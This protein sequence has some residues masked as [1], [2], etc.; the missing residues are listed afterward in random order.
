MKELAKLWQ[1]LMRSNGDLSFL[2][3]CCYECLKFSKLIRFWRWGTKISLFIFKQ[4]STT[5]ECCAFPFPKESPWGRWTAGKPPLFPGCSTLQHPSGMCWL[6][7]H[8]LLPFLLFPSCFY[9][10]AQLV[11]LSFPSFWPDLGLS[12]GHWIS[13]QPGLY[14]WDRS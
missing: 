1:L 10:L 13:L 8:V 14:C 4:N 3:L 5:E 2:S 12:T 7:S 6:G 11:G 9:F